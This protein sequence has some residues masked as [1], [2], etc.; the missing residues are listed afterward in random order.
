MCVRSQTKFFQSHHSV[1]VCVCTLLQLAQCKTHSGLVLRIDT[2]HTVGNVKHAQRAALLLRSVLFGFDRLMSV[3]NARRT[4]RHTN[5]RLNA[6]NIEIKSKYYWIL[7]SVCI[8][9]FRKYLRRAVCELRS[10]AKSSRVGLSE[11]INA[12]VLERSVVMVLKGKASFSDHR[13]R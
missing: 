11:V 5:C 2:R 1:C 10:R 8:H 6:N 7:Y 12:F 3:R 4:E 9:T 13:W